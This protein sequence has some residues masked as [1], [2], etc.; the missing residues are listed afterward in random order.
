M[1]ILF[2]SSTR[3]GD[4]VLS[5]ALLD[6]LL[7]AHP[8][9]RITVACGPV[10]TG[11]FARMPGLER[12]ITVTKQRWSLH[13]L[14][15]WAQVVTRRW[16]LVVDLRGSAI[17]WMLL[18]RRR[19]VMRGGRRP[20]H[21]LLH[22]A[23]TLGLSPAPRPVAWY[24]PEDVAQ[25]AALLGVGGGPILALGPTA[26]WVRK[27]WPAERFLELAR[28]LTAPDGSLAGARILVL[29]GP[30]AEER[31]AAAPVLAGLPGAIDLVGVASL[32]EVAA[33]LARCALFVGND[34]G[35]MHLAAAV[36]VPTI[37]LFGPTPASEYGP[38]G[39]RAAA[40]LAEGPPGAAPMADLPVDAVVAAATGLLA[41]AP[42]DEVLA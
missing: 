14:G 40:V 17:A 36:G 22:L 29:G 38:V 12:L 24:A 39:R 10:A 34:S 32:P 13:W 15:L 31:T 26:N 33:A 35:L 6:H 8:G 1:R 42:L 28:R 7:R 30:G 27:V 41:R 37:G 5:T 16:D 25:A 3:I 23:Q 2:I 18:A 9:A 4:A 11:V 20:G 21:R 19:A